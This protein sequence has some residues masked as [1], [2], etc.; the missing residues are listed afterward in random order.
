MLG[1]IEEGQGKRKVKFNWGWG[2]P[3][4]KQWKIIGQ[5]ILNLTACAVWPA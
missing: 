3:K 1:G 4:Q 2:L 5:E